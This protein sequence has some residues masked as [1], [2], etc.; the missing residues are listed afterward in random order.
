MARIGR[1][2]RGTENSWRL[3]GSLGKI[4]YLCAINKKGRINNCIKPAQR[5]SPLC[6]EDKV[7]R[8]GNIDAQ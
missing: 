8:H 1:V 4:H 6:T 5:V 2:Y 3:F 7:K